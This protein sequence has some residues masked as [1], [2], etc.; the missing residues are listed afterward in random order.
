MRMKLLGEE[1]DMIKLL[2]I[3]EKHGEPKNVMAC[4]QGMAYMITYTQAERLLRLWREH[5]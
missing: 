3:C 4:Y 1:V 2:K 5:A